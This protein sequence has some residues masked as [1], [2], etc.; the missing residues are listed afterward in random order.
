LQKPW[1]ETVI[2]LTTLNSKVEAFAE[3][4]C[5]DVV[6]ADET[7]L[8]F[9]EQTLE[10]QGGRQYAALI[11][12]GVPHMFTKWSRSQLLSHLGTREKWFSSVTVR[13]Q[14]QELSIRTHTLVGHMLRTMKTYDADS[15]VR[16]VRG[17]VS[18]KFGDIPDTQV[19]SSLLEHMPEGR[20]LAGISGKT[21]RAFYAY[22]VSDE[23]IG[24]APGLQRFRASPGLVVK[25][26][27]VGYSSLWVYPMLMFSH[28]VAVIENK[29]LRQI[30]RGSSEGLIEKMDDAIQDLA[31]VWG[32]IE[33]RL[34]ALHTLT[35][36]DEDSAV[37]AMRAALL[38]R[39]VG[40]TKLFAYQCEQRYRKQKH[41][42]HTGAE[43]LA[44]VLDRGSVLSDKD[45]AYT[46]ASAAGALLFAL[47]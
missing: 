45:G 42:L 2:P 4:C 25:N 28:G 34:A 33:K 39:S 38:G 3:L 44:A 21:D 16:L 14:A 11:L 30:H 36:P 35:W 19:M 24:V 27:E 31:A 1:R 40:A 17:I 43:V 46:Q 47:R 8:S 20:C 15:D 22:A 29:V 32:P 37:N 13:Q 9:Q 5:P 12:G 41:S 10:D 7:P 18:A 6:V 26:S 23:I